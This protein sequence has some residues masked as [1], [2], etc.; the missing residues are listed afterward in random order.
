MMDEPPHLHHVLPLHPL[1][2]LDGLHT[3]INKLQPPP[4]RPIRLTSSRQGGQGTTDC[5][6]VTKVSVEDV[7]ETASLR[8]QIV[9][10]STNCYEVC[11]CVC[12]V[13]M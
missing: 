10:G 6:H 13:Y 7:E 5:E 11:V 9:F 3:F 8:E 12:C 4:L 2:P 1:H